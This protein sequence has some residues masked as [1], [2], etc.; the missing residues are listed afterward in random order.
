MTEQQHSPI[1]RT[2]W[3]PGP[4]DQEPD[5]VEFKTAAGFPGL[6]VRHEIGHWCGYVA[7][8]PGHP[9][10]GHGYMSE[11]EKGADGWD[12]YDRPIH[13]PVDSLSVHGGIT[14]AEKCAGD[15][16]HVPEPGEPDDVF[17]LGFDCAH[18]W[19]LSP[20]DWEHGRNWP[21]HHY[22][23]AAYVR[24]ECESLAEQLAAIVSKATP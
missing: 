18:A 22:R 15:V 17:W 12:D 24:A 9:C 1:D 23:D 2:G 10:H 20:R 11:Y 3:P 19:D 14:Y 16:C 5:R 21:D 13:N 6:I 8:P 7:V 4:W